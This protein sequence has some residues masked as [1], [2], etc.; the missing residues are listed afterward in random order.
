MQISWEGICT[1]HKKI[2]VAACEYCKQF[3]KLC[4]TQF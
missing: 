1:Y 4:N 2:I 3:V